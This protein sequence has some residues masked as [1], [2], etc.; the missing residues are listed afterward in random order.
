MAPE[1]LS[2]EITLKFDIY[3]LGVIIKD[4]LGVKGDAIVKDVR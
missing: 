1:F 3:S 2:G 4:I